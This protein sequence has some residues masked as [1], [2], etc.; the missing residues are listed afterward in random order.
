MQSVYLKVSSHLDS[1]AIY[2]FGVYSPTAVKLSRTLHPTVLSFSA[3]LTIKKEYHI[4]TLSSIDTAILPEL[5]LKIGVWPTILLIEGGN[6]LSIID[7]KTTTLYLYRNFLP[8]TISWQPGAVVFASEKHYFKGHNS[9]F[10]N[11]RVW[12]LPPYSGI[13]LSPKGYKFYDKIEK[14]CGL[15][16]R[17]AWENY[18]DY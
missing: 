17:T 9:P 4:N 6:A 3:S 7:V 14:L 8:L 13:E 15:N 11:H 1:Y 16:H 2:I 5:I 18:P 12:E 10:L